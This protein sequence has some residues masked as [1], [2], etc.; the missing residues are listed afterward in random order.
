[1]SFPEEILAS[2]SRE[3]VDISKLNRTTGVYDEAAVNASPV[4]EAAVA[5]GSEPEKSKEVVKEKK[6]RRDA[7]GGKSVGTSPSI[8]RNK[9][10]KSPSKDTKKKGVKI[11]KSPAK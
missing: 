3:G 2:L 1:M 10:A 8:S 6:A 7:P 5:R 4:A 11:A 9:T